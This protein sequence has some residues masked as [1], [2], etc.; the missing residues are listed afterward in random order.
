MIFKNLIVLGLVGLVNACVTEPYVPP[1][2][3]TGSYTAPKPKPQPPIPEVLTTDYDYWGCRDY[4]SSY[5]ARPLIYV[6]KH[7]ERTSLGYVMLASD[8]SPTLATYEKQGLEHR[9][10]WGL[11]D[12]QKSYQY[13]FNI[14]PDGV[15]AYY[16]FAMADENGTAKPQDLYKCKAG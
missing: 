12:D 9:W 3:P 5:N 1:A 14:K 8:S 15:G 16:N 11:D 13:S 6:G 10:N 2:T 7:H 4:V